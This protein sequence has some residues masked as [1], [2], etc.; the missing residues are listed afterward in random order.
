[1]RLSQKAL[2]TYQKEG[3]T[4][5]LK[6][7]NRYLLSK[8]SPKPTVANNTTPHLVWSLKHIYNLIFIT[9]HGSGT[10]VISEDW[11]TL[12]LLDACRFDDFQKINTLEGKLEYRISKAVDSRE[13]I[14]KNFVGKNHTDIAYVTANPHVKL[15]NDNVF[16]DIITAPLSNWDSDL[17]CVPPAEVTKAAIKSHRKYSNKRI[18][19]HYMQPHGPPLGPTGDVLRSEFQ[20]EGPRTNEKEGKRMMRLVAEGKISN[21]HARKAYRETLK[22]V[23]SEVEELIENISGKVVISAD[24]GEMFGENPYFFLGDLYEHY[25]NPKTKELCKVPWFILDAD[26]RR[27]TGSKKEP[28]E[29]QPETNSSVD[30][31]KQLK[32]LGYK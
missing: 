21:Y 28:P 27:S 17:Q 31:E 12:I 9:E 6:K 16:Y 7:S 18:I 20:I 10:D 2:E 13:F 1:M 30:L 3:I 4:A 23:L 26:S 15:I 22:I 19:V 14:K 29:N 5:L 11:D 25:G 32:A 24:H 8:I